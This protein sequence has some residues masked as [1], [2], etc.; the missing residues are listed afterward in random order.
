MSDSR[1]EIL[2]KEYEVAQEAVNAQNA[3]AWQ[4]G[5]IFIIASLGILAFVAQ[6]TFEGTIVASWK[7]SMQILVVGAISW[8]TLCLWFRS[9]RRWGTFVEIS[10]R[11]MQEIEA[12]LG[13]WKNRDIELVDSIIQNRKRDSVF[14]ND[15]NV[16]HATRVKSWATRMSQRQRLV[17]TSID[18]SIRGIV[19]LNLFGWLAISVYQMPGGSLGLG[20]WWLLIPAI[21]IPVVWFY[22]PRLVSS[23]S[24]QK[25]Q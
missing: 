9:Y 4:I 3:T 17:S 2:L 18:M 22:Y 20:K 21:A 25:H 5:S 13:M 24:R 7:S 11:R 1:E 10:H 12:E 19:A 16:D 15:E 14:T 6:K 8:G 23:T